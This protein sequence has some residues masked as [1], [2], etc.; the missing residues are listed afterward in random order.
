MAQ[1]DTRRA[2]IE[3]NLVKYER[4]IVER[5]VL[6]EEL[7]N[8]VGKTLQFDSGPLPQ[9]GAYVRGIDDQQRPVQIFVIERPASVFGMTYRIWKLGT[10]HYN[11]RDL[12]DN[13]ISLALSW[14]RTLWCYKFV[15]EVMETV[16]LVGIKTPLMDRYRESETVALMVPNIHDHGHGHFCTGE[17]KIPM[18]LAMP[19]R[20]AWLHNHLQGSA[21]NQD[22][23]FSYPRDCGVTDLFD[24]NEKS[25]IDSSYYKKM[26]FPNHQLRTVGGLIDHLM[27][28]TA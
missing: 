20:I 28:R 12:P 21:W 17:V 3:G 4:V 9:G 26:K 13:D 11:S 22:L 5:E 7:V 24:W 14:P 23:A 2:V 25:R 8:T 15:K 27:R 1:S 19:K 16:H 10:Q 18:D 6:L